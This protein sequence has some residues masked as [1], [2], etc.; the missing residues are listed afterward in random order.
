M[1]AGGGCLVRLGRGASGSHLQA[2][3]HAGG[4]GLGAFLAM[5][6]VI[7]LA[8]LLAP[9][10][11]FGTVFADQRREL[12]RLAMPAQ[13]MSSA[14]Q[15]VIFLVSG[16]SRQAAAHLRHAAAAALQAAIQSA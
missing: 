4:A 1:H 12:A 15:R 3:L 14:M 16:S 10:A 11:H 7:A 6:M 2:H 9:L 5:P 8:F 13:S